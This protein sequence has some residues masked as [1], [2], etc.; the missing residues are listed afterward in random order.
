MFYGQPHI[1]PAQASEWRMDVHNGPLS[2]RGS[3]SSH[4][5]NTRTP[6]S[7]GAGHSSRTHITRL[8]TPGVCCTIREKQNCI[9]SLSVSANQRRD[10]WVTD[11][12]EASVISVLIS[13]GMSSHRPDI[14]L[15]DRGDTSV[16]TNSNKTK[17]FMLWL[18]MHCSKTACRQH[19]FYKWNGQTNTQRH[20]LSS[21]VR[22]SK[23]TKC[24]M[25]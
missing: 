4:Q 2:P 3:V 24:Q 13:D 19:E 10:M 20:F 1:P 17:Y 18:S 21:W 25:T 12:W 5:N 15:R 16:V 7:V 9:K 6:V 23:L 22:D 8:E 11:Q 14:A